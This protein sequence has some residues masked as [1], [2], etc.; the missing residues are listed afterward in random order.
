MSGAEMTHPSTV[1]TQ[2]RIQ[3]YDGD[4]GALRA[5]FE[6]AEDS[7]SALDAY[8]D[9]GRVLVALL[10]E[11]IVGHL[12]AVPTARA[13]EV[14]IK[15]MAVLTC[16]QGRGL[17]R[18]LIA[19]LVDRLADEPVTTVLVAT[20]AADVDNLRFYQRCGFRLRS[21]ERDAFTEATGY[22]AGIVIDGIELRDR[23][24]LD[25]SLR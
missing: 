24:W 3:P 8:V 10:D 15:N 1:A 22:P 4:R 9:E 21:I 12:Q 14:E 17:G 7:S 23:V 6:L 18:A 13:D 2:P 25:R 19:S 20:A 5:L 11:Q 16:H